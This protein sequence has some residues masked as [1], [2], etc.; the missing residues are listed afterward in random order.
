MRRVQRIDI[1]CR[2][3]C[4]ARWHVVQTAAADRLALHELPPLPR[5]APCA[6]G[7]CAALA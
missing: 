6:P 2:A 3:H 7:G 1:E 4:R 5:A